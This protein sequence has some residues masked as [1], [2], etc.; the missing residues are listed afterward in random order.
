MYDKHIFG[1]S[2]FEMNAKISIFVNNPIDQ[3]DGKN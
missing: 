3:D 1:S 2:Y